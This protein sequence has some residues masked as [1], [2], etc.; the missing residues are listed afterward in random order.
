M[1]KSTVLV[2]SQRGC[3]GLLTLALA[4]GA[5]AAAA[6][7]ATWSAPDLDTWAYSNAFGGGSRPL[8]PTFTGGLEVDSQT[9]E[10]LPQPANGPSRVGMTLAAFDTT[11]HITAGLAP[12]R[13][14]I[15]SVAVTLTMESG[16]GGSLPYDST[17]DARSEILADVLAGD[18][19]AQRPIELYGVGF[20]LGYDGFALGGASG[21]TKFGESTFPY[22]S[23]GSGYRAYP[24]VGDAAQ[25]GQ[26]RDVSNNITGGFSATSPGNAA[27]SFDATPW[28]VGTVA[29]LNDG[30]A[31]PDR[32]TFTF[33]LNLIEP[34]VASYL[35]QSLSTGALG[36][37]FSTL[38]AATQPG[39]GESLGYPQWYMKESVGGIYNGVPATLDIDYSILPEGLAGDFDR[40]GDVDGGDFLKWQQD[41]G[42]PVGSAGEGADANGN[43]VVDGPDLDYWTGNFGA[44]QNAI[45]A[46]VP[47]PSALA[48]AGAAVAPLMMRRRLSRKRRRAPPAAACSRRSGFS[49]IELLVVIAIVGVLIA[50]LLPA[51]QSARETSRRMS[52]QNRLKQIGLAVQNF[53]SAKAHLPPPKAGG[54]TYNDLGSTFVLLLPYI[55]QWQLFASYDLE[56]T[57]VDPHNLPITEK[58][59]DL[60]LCPSMALPRDVPDR[61]CGEQLAPGSYAISSRT[62]YAKHGN[63]D[64]AF[65]NPP[66]DG[67][68]SLAARHITDGLSNTLLVGEVNFG[69][70]GYL[71]E[72]CDSH[73]GQTKWGDHTWA[74]GYWALSWGHMSARYPELF[75]NS[76]YYGGADSNRVF[77]SDHSGGVQFVMLDGSV[78]FLT[79]ETDPAIRR[80]LVTRAG[81]EVHQRLN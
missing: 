77:R 36:F 74:H 13:Y 45:V 48:L 60:F 43:Q 72:N 9:Q 63:L 80:A 38:H 22:G 73:N 61:S 11:A 59:V 71:W 62:E 75:N 41:L 16:S 44:S 55:E 10:F 66:N 76:S 68:Y 39:T 31:I 32:T 69:H 49:L 50:L 27:A 33:N 3:V 29:T 35:Q 1:L 5:S 6:A 26:Y 18:Y 46:A 37:F 23:S 21:P 40:D 30:D 78:H 52:C 19:D 25:P 8:A 42:S 34:G 64:G 17:P 47:E 2:T 4:A 12:T 20:R 67:N 51:V 14:Q 57:T 15:N 58:P 56:K 70:H 24:I 65:Q 28:A 7:T 79:T 54:G 53:E 81:D